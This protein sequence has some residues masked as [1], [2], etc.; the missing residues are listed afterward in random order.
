MSESLKNFTETDLQKFVAWFLGN[1]KPNKGDQKL[2]ACARAFVE[3]LI[4]QYEETYGEKYNLKIDDKLKIT[5]MEV[6]NHHPEI[7]NPKQKIDIRDKDGKS[8]EIDF[9]V[10][11]NK[12]YF[13]IIEL[14]SI[15]THEHNN[16]LV[17][18]IESAKKWC[19]E[20]ELIPIPIYLKIGTT[21]PKT[22]I[23]D[24]ESEE[25]EFKYISLS[26]LIE[27]FE[28]Y[29][30]NDEIFYSYLKNF[31]EIEK[32]GTAYT[33]PEMKIEKWSYEVAEDDENKKPWPE[34][35]WKVLEQDKNTREWKVSKQ[36]MMTPK[37]ARIWECWRGFY[38]YL[39]SKMELE[40]TDWGKK[41]VRGT[42]QVNADFWWPPIKW[43]YIK[44]EKEYEV[45]L[46][47]KQ[48]LW[49]KQKNKEL[50]IQGPLCF[51]I[52]TNKESVIKDLYYLLKEEMP[53]IEKRKHKTRPIIAIIIE[54]KNWLGADNDIVKPENVVTKL[55]EIRKALEKALK[56]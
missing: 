43:K 7:D 41:S 55:K 34:L 35:K 49:E 14:K 48:V 32:A 26:N 45:Q 3:Y 23:K 47:I 29:K 19:E 54:R 37:K 16:Q 24:I 9:C 2:N 38:S 22:L 18:Y 42:P 13:I 11:I 28:K 50:H 33:E 56:S 25:K 36:D 53:E 12:K 10:N 31:K 46:R 39:E 1:A 17:R 51:E 8:Q 4:K 52:N 5:S 15:F 27:E 21:E 30:L 6:Y 44:D 40:N 20:K